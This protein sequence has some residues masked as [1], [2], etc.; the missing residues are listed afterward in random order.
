MCMFCDR[1]AKNTFKIL[2]M[3]KVLKKAFE[4]YIFSYSVVV[5]FIYYSIFLSHYDT[6]KKMYKQK[7]LCP[8]FDKSLKIYIIYYIHYFNYLSSILTY[9]I[10][11]IIY[12]YYLHSIY[13]IH[14]TYL[15]KCI[16]NNYNSFVC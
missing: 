2:S 12:R 6:V 14:S 13:N 10:Y 7:K 8:R 11:C 3:L 15:I 4:C 16:N 5:T 9:S 1:V